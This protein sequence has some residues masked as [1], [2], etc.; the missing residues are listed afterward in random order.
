MACIAFILFSNS[1]ILLWIAVKKEYMKL[2]VGMI[3]SQ[4]HF[5][6]VVGTQAWLLRLLYSF[7]TRIFLQYV[8]LEKEFRKQNCR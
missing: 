7:L 2:G 3:M 4:A 6:I 1:D 5:D 8:V